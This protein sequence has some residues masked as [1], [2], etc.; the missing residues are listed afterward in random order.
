MLLG[1]RFLGYTLVDLV[2]IV[3]IASHTAEELCVFIC[4]RRP[5]SV[6]QQKEPEAEPS[7]YANKILQSGSSARQISEYSFNLADSKRRHMTRAQI[8]QEARLEF[9]TLALPS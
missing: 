3:H 8:M 4:S 1:N 9:Q 6:V 2:D 5:T 7:S